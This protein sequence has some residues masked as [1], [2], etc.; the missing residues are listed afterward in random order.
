MA[1]DLIWIE[2]SVEVEPKS[3]AHLL[4]IILVELWGLGLHLD[5]TR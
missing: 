5:L 2:I 1:A 3:D 4:R